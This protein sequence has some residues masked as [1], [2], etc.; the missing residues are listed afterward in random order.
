M[1]DNSV[2]A[3]LRATSLRWM[4][5]K[6]LALL[7]IFVLIAGSSYWIGYSKGKS[8]GFWQE[9]SSTLGLAHIIR[10]PNGLTESGAKR[11]HELS[12]IWIYGYFSAPTHW[13]SEQKEEEIEKLLV[14]LI[15]W[16]IES[17]RPVGPQEALVG[18][19]PL[20]GL[21]AEELTE[22]NMFTDPMVEHY[23]DYKER[24][25]DFTERHKLRIQPVDAANASNA[26]SDNLDQSARIR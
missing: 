6:I 4:K 7:L 26:A 15:E 20:E 21:T 9:F 13:L 12:D 19:K 23:N 11:M 5:K 14:K 25:D 3:S 10:T 22:E 18:M 24:F 1:V 17:G 8:E 2:R 16:K